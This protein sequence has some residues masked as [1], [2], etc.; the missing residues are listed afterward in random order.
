MSEAA[1]TPQSNE[2]LQQE[3][4]FL[5]EE[6]RVL[7]DKIDYLLKR[8]RGFKSEKLDPGQLQL[9]LE[10][11]EPNKPEDQTDSQQ[12]DEPTNH[13]QSTANQAKRK[14]G[15]RIKLPSNIPTKEIELVPD[16]VQEHPDQWVR[17]GEKRT[18]KLDVTPPSYH[19]T[20][21]IRGTYAPKTPG[22]KWTTAPLPDQLLDKSVLTPS[23]LADLL[24][25]K[26]CDH[27][28]FYRQSQILRRRFGI[29]ISR[30][31]LC[32]WADLAAELS[33]PLWKLIAQLIQMGEFVQV[34]ETPVNYLP[35]DQPGS[36]EGRFWVY[37]NAEGLVLYDWHTSRSH[38]CLFNILGEPGD[39]QDGASG[40][41]FKGL[42]QCDGYSAYPTYA[43]KTAGQIKLGGCWAHVRRKFFEA[44]EDDSRALKPLQMIQ[45]LYADEREL[46]E[47]LEGKSHP[48]GAIAHL[49]RRHNWHR[50][51][52]APLK[53]HLHKLQKQ[54]LPK[55]KLGRAISYTLNQWMPLCQ[56]LKHAPRLDNNDVENDVRPLKLGAKNW[57]FI[58]NEDTGWRSAVIYTLIE[59]VRSL[60]R[61]P[62]EYLKWYFERIMTMTNQDDL[63]ELL[64][65]AWAEA[66]PPAWEEVSEPAPATA[67][68]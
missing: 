45:Q 29:H 63:S 24:I 42:L 48:P 20:I 60:D 58:G 40:E 28:P 8:I 33:E 9:M 44:K 10:G 31:T 25:R 7:R 15:P 32:E 66:N 5:R 55:S 53:E 19:K 12:D 43:Q 2:S 54:I 65:T 67:T 17:I 18:E 49:R 35:S 21:Y 41:H 36:K 26:F 50:K 14:R 57:L 52:L 56:T 13:N 39:K 46:R 64:P 23:L 51:H 27:L 34:D 61:D 22:A 68:A 4:S 3:I 1:N 37:R 6:N 30:K 62:F 59:N 38:Q 16:D 47:Q 11:I